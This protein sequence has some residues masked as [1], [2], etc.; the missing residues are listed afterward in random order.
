MNAFIDNVCIFVIEHCLLDE[1]RTLLNHEVV[2][3]MDD[4]VLSSLAAESSA[5]QEE[6][7]QLTKKVDTL[8]KGLQTCSQYEVDAV[9]CTFM[10][11]PALFKT[12][13]HALHQYSGLH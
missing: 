2:G 5:A 7:K 8:A 12:S 9:I 6:R 10:L 4:P 11:I 13:L 3:D 1:L